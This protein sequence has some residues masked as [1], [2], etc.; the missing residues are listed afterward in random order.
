[1]SVQFIFT[2]YYIFH[3]LTLRNK[4][5]GRGCRTPRRPPQFQQ[6]PSSE[7]RIRA[8]ESVT[9][10]VLYCT[11]NYDFMPFFIVFHC[12]HLSSLSFISSN[13]HF[14]SPLFTFL[15]RSYSYF[16]TSSHTPLSPL[17]LLPHQSQRSLRTHQDS[18]C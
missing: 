11:G 10:Y 14:I 7:R 13:L 15:F 16:T 4:G 1:M 18:R 17:T 8:L 5:R 6:Q 12:V 9:R 3:L 2:S